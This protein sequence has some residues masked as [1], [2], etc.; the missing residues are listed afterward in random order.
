MLHLLG[1]D[2]TKITCRHNGRDFRLA[3]V[4]HR[5]IADWLV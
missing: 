4:H 5:A 2:E 1:L 3:D